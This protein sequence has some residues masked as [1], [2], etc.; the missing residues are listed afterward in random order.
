MLSLQRPKGQRENNASG[1][2]TYHVSGL[3]IMD[4]SFPK[5]HFA[6]VGNLCWR[7]A[8]KSVIKE[9]VSVYLSI[10]G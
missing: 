2:E 4:Q 10:K 8:G 6:R 3:P 5:S 1:I 7:N 9:N